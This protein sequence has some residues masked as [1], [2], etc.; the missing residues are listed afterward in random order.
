MPLKN[1][2]LWLGTFH[3]L[4][5]QSSAALFTILPKE[6]CDPFLSHLTLSNFPHNPLKS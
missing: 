6:L 3:T 5:V 4:R 2:R 1:H